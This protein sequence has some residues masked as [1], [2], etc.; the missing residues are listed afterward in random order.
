MFVRKILLVEDEK[1]PASNIRKSLQKLGYSVSEISK[2][3]NETIKKVAET[4]PNVVLIDICLAKDT[5]CMQ[6]A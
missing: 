2:C 6:V 1:I 4:H 5:D 3:S